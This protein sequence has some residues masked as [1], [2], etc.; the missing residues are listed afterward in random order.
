MIYLF[1]RYKLKNPKD[2]IDPAKVRAHMLDIVTQALTKLGFKTK[3][4]VV[5]PAVNF[6]IPS[7]E[8]SFRYID[9]DLVL[10]IKQDKWPASADPNIPSKL[11]ARGVGLVPKVLEAPQDTKVW[12]ISFTAAEI[13]LFQGIDEDEGCQKKLLKIAKYLKLASKWPDT[14][15]SYHLKT[16]LMKMNRDHPNKDDWTDSKIVPRFEELMS[17]FLKAL[18][19]GKLPSFFIP[20]FDLFKGKDLRTAIQRVQNLIRAIETNP[21]SCFPPARA[22]CAPA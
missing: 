18:Q 5:G 12:Q 15:S 9:I 19:A 1:N 22:P 7:R 4:T 8:A 11:K 21:D 10:Y 2:A 20:N 17:S 16:I 6:Q 14:V 13:I 3:V